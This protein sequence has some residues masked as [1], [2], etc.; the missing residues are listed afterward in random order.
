[1]AKSSI[2]SKFKFDHRRF[3]F[4]SSLVSMGYV[5]L[6][7]KSHTKKRS[8]IAAAAAVDVLVVAVGSN[9]NAYIYNE[10]AEKK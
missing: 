4:V 3:C 2:C 1:M 10:P 5:A 6:G 8:K 9:M 7:K